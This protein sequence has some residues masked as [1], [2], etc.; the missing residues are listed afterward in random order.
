M[1]HVLPYVMAAASV[2]VALLG[3]MALQPVLL[4]RALLALFIVAVTVNALYGGIGPALLATGLSVLANLFFLLPP[5]RS[6]SV[7][8]DGQIVLALFVVSAVLITVVGIQRTGAEKALHD[9]EQRYRLLVEGSGDYA[10]FLLDPNGR[11]TS[12]NGGAQGLM[13]YNEEDVLGQHFSLFF[14]P[15]EISSGRPD[16]ELALAAGTGRARSEGW[17]V[18]KD[19]S[20]FYAHGF[21]R[22]VRDKRQLRAY[23]KIMHDVTPWYRAEQRLILQYTVSRVLAESES[24]EQGIPRVL[25]AICVTLGW[26]YAALWEVDQRRHVLRCGMIWHTPSLKFPRF[27]ATCRSLSFE[28]GEDLPGRVWANNEAAWVSDISQDTN[29]PRT[30][31]ALAE[32]L[33]SAFA[34]PLRI[35]TETLGTLEFFQRQTSHADAEVLMLVRAVGS[36]VGQFIERKR[37]EA[38][39]QEAAAHTRAIVDTAIDGIITIDARGTI[40]S[41]NRAAERL[42]GHPR[43]AMIG[44]NIT[45]LM[46]LSFRE[47]QAR[48]VT[49]WPNT[50][51]NGITG[52]GR[53]ALGVRKDGGVFP[54][55]VSI[56]EVHF[57]D[58]RVFTAIVR[59]ISE[60]KRGEEE[61]TAALQRERQA[62]RDAEEASRA[63]DEFL[64]VISHEL[65]TP[66]TPILTWS[67]L[68]RTGKLDPG[69][70]ERALAAVE[71][72]ARSQARLIEDLLD[73]SRVTSGKLRLDVR[74]IEL[75]PVVEAAVES[76]RPAA[77]AKGIRFAL[78]LDRNAGMVSGDAERLQQVVWNLVSNAIKFTPRGGR[79]QVRL[80]AVNSHVELAVSDTGQGI[81]ADF[82]PHVFERFRQ[83][84]SSSTRAHGGLGL[85]LAIV[86]HLVELHGGRV[87]AESAG[88]GKGS[89][90]I[91]ELPLAIMHR[92]PGPDRVHPRA[93]D[94]LPFDPPRTLGNVKILI[95]DDEP[96]TLDT[97][98]A[99]LERAGAQVR[100]A[101]SA[102]EALGALDEWRADV[103]ISDIGMP[104]EDGYALIRKVRAL[105]PERG[106][107]I[108]AV[109]LT[110]YARMED[111]LKV[112]SSG[113]Q[114]HLPKPVEPAELIAIM[115]NLSVWGGVKDVGRGG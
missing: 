35:G 8:T 96:D 57:N 73:V 54:I 3:T 6:F 53:E 14:T 108:P 50:G 82:L 56:S 84:D 89:T 51:G 62:R 25:E 112:L 9:S 10:M 29:F 15:V 18:R 104:D 7:N 61:R 37:A 93:G 113:F 1:R 45:L 38:A 32:G 105:D 98:R 103:L 83:A 92:Q 13:G 49:D 11:V 69:A 2:V 23:A 16:E 65:R 81:P 58:R 12:W 59:D 79:V 115:A 70:T 88:E 46:P 52:I 44:Q 94:A 24:V 40:A 106:G 76:V 17:R 47:E 102:P 48:P 110:A 99:V 97:L 19:G 91:V 34:V 30:P 87:H 75:S 71:R 101:G 72:A 27:S 55:D 21:V 5:L 66:L 33:R 36:H 60:R 85:G 111:R 95:V 114:M 31:V 80:Q 86:R 77:D 78:V 28:P 63:K 42:F 22:A 26:D 41:A 20:R 100:T 107:Y 90:F 39:A 4:G 43:A 68:L 67:R 64:A 74:Q 109:A